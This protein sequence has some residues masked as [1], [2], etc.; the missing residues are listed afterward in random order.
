[1]AFINGIRQT[2]TTVTVPVSSTDNAAVRFDGTT[3]AV[4]QNSGVIITDGNVVQSGGFE[5]VS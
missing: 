2:A 5:V 3:G 4:I 1:M